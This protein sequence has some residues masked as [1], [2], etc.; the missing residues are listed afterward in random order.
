MGYFPNEPRERKS[1]KQSRMS[2]L[3]FTTDAGALLLL[4]LTCATRPLTADSRDAGVHGARVD[5]PRA[6]YGAR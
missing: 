3:T 4:L 2:T 6:V 1:F 5:P